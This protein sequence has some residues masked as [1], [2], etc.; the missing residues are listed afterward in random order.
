MSAKFSLQS[1]RTRLNKEL[2]KIKNM[3]L[4]SWL[5]E[6]SKIEG[7][8]DALEGIYCGRE[9]RVKAE[10]SGCYRGLWITFGWYTVIAPK[11]E[12]AYVS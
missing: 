10:L 7:L 6:V 2:S 12:F 9:G 4:Q 3:E 11:I 1:K 5:N 8:S